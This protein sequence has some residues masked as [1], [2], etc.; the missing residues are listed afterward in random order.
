MCAGDTNPNDVFDASVEWDIY[1]TDDATGL[2]AHT[3]E[4]GGGSGP[5]DPVINEFVANH[6]GADSEAFIEVFGS[7]STD[8]SGY[9]VLEIEGDDSGA[10][11]IDAV[12]PVTTTSADGYWV[13]PEDMENGTITILLVE[14]FTGSSGQDLDT[15]NDGTFDV[16]PWTGVVDDV[17]VTDGGSSDVVYSSTVL[18]PFYDGQA[19]GPGGASRIPNGTDTDTAGDWV[20][21]DF[22]GFG[23]PGFVGTQA[24]GEA[25][26][27]PGAVN[28]VI[29]VIVDPEGV[30]GDPATFIHDIQG[31]GLASDDIGNIRE[32]E[33]VVVGD[34]QDDLGVNGDLNG[35]HVQEEDS[36]ADDNA[37]TSEGIFVFQ[38]SDPTVDVA[39]GDVVRVRGSV[40][41]FNGMTEINNV[42]SVEACGTGSATAA[43]VT[44]V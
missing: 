7:P 35:F 28:V 22:D 4:C 24:I 11:V 5:A 41:E 21:N 34:F 29:T 13:D 14:G 38:G 37:A 30:C 44:S 36:D 9:T 10:G 19:F 27:T 42:E 3:A 39:L 20:R 2:G 25:V 43:T 32:I 18:A 31:S 12:L 23:F 33:G 15:D 16:T 1:A 8:Y 40:T 26:N 6:T 17:A